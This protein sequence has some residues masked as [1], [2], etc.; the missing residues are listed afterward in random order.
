MPGDLTIGFSVP[1]IGG[2]AAP[3]FR[4]AAAPAPA[5][6]LAS[7]PGSPNPAL[8][9]DPAVGLVVLQFQDGVDGATTTI[10][11]QQQLDAYRNG[12]AVP[13]GRAETA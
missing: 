7:E 12:S 3:A 13:P 6:A 1:A 8:R 5:A 2:P 9:L 10:P 4:A 11:S